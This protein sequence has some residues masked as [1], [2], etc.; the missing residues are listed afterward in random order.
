MGLG[1]SYFGLIAGGLFGVALGE[2][3]DPPLHDRQ[4]Q[5]ET[6]VGTVAE[7]EWAI[8][9]FWKCDDESVARTIAAIAAAFVPD[10]L[11][12]Q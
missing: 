1:R 11:E 4:K 5:T 2:L 6:E 8:D 3:R 12:L 10:G 9:G 7:S